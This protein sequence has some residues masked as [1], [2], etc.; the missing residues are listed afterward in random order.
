MTSFWILPNQSPPKNRK[1]YYHI[2]KVT[3]QT[4]VMRLQLEVNH[5][6]T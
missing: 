1:L 6:N 2:L 5:L 3:K 4:P